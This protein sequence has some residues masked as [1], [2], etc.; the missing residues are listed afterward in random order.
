MS[1]DT[2]AFKSLGLLYPV[3][4]YRNYCVLMHVVKPSGRVAI[5][6]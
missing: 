6:W 2:D 4:I 5:C 1:S 3:V